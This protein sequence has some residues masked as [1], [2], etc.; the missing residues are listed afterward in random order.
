MNTF[1]DFIQE[2]DMLTDEIVNV[3]K[4]MFDLNEEFRKTICDLNRM[5]SEFGTLR[6]NVR[7]LQMMFI[8]A[9]CSFMLSLT[10]VIVCI[11]CRFNDAINNFNDTTE[12]ST[13]ITVYSTTAETTKAKLKTATNKDTT[14]SKDI[15]KSKNAVTYFD[16]P[17]SKDLQNHIFNLC[18]NYNVKPSIII[19]MIQRESNFKS[20]AIGD[21]GDSFGLMQIQPKWHKERMQRLNCTDLLDPYQNVTVGIDIFAE[22]LDE[23]KGLE[24]ALM[25][26]NGGASYADKKIADGIVSNY[27]K[28]VILKSDNF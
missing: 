22:L 1:N 27:A 4:E 17:L 23:D 9:C 5:K 14:K 12:T 11:G 10:I 16:V 25:A 24:W 26:Y 20:K 13:T 6:N 28:D 3:Q 7:C 2:K 8:G 21:N 15:T 18:A 19:A